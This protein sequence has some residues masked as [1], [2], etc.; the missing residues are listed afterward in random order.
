MK[1][2]GRPLVHPVRRDVVGDHPHRDRPV[3][4]LSSPKASRVKNWPRERP[5]EGYRSVSKNSLN[6]W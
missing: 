6:R 4:S 1:S 2:L 3:T 5:S